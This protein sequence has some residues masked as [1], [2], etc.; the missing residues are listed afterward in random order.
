MQ[1]LILVKQKL[2]YRNALAEKELLG[3]TAKVIGNVTDDL[4]DFTFD[5][6]MNLFLKLFTH[7]K[8]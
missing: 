6:A 8:E 3:T 7:K 1:E 2:H 5:L 4:K